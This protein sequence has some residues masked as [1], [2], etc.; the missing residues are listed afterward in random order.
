[1][2]LATNE[3]NRDDTAYH[4]IIKEIK[5]ENEYLAFVKILQDY[6]SDAF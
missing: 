3:I 1:L 6:G 5:D 2:Y 4:K